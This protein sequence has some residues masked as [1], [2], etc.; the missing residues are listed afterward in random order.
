MKANLRA[1]M[2]DEM[3]EAYSGLSG[4][5]AG[6][7]SSGGSGTPH[8]GEESKFFDPRLAAKGAAKPR[9]AGFSFVEPG[10]FVREGQQLRMKAQLVRLQSEI[11]TIA[12]KT[13]I[14]SAAQLAKLV[15]KGD[16]K[17]KIPEVE[18]WDA[19]I[20]NPGERNLSPWKTC[21]QKY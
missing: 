17:G 16:D 10:K 9:R 12:R 1:K 8:V 4:H 14:T 19:L 2:R 18:W 6:S 13:G 5:G 7:S 11:S 15:P 3:K 21:S 20:L